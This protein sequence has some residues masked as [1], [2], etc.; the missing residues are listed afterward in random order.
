MKTR[1]FKLQIS[2]ETVGNVLNTIK[3]N[4]FD[5][6]QLNQCLVLTMS[7]HCPLDE[8]LPR[9]GSGLGFDVVNAAERNERLIAVCWRLVD[10]GVNSQGDLAFLANL[11]M[12]STS[13]LL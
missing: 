5:L 8:S 9:R 7:Q 3:T 6:K 12:R 13:K 2:E 1:G 10:F 4:N 11:H